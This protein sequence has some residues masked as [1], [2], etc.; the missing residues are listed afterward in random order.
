MKTKMSA[1]KKILVIGIIVLCVVLLVPF[2]LWYKDGGT[3]ELKALL[4]SVRK[5]HSI[6]TEARGYDIGTRVRIIAWKV[7]DDVKFVPEDELSKNC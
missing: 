2:P 5:V 4:W 6:S 1:H 7:Y 3:F